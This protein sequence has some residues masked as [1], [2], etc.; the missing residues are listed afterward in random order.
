MMLTAGL[1]FSHDLNNTGKEN[2]NVS[3]K[4]SNPYS[5]HQKVLK[6][7]YKCFVPTTYHS[8]DLLVWSRL[9]HLY[10]WKY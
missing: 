9:T 4:S 3:P 1:I 8:T 10:C 2:S 7:P 6:Q 5:D